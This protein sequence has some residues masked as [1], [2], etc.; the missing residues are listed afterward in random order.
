MVWMEQGPPSA[1]E[2]RVSVSWG[3]RQRSALAPQ[4]APA[5][6]QEATSARRTQPVRATA[7]SLPEYNKKIRE[8]R[9]ERRRLIGYFKTVCNGQMPRAVHVNTNVKHKREQK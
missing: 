9:T 5:V 6:W 8:C 7:F 2:M 3:H 1:Q 4:P